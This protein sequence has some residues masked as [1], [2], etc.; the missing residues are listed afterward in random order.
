[1]ASRPLAAPE[2]ESSEEGDLVELVLRDQAEKAVYPERID[3]VVVGRVVEIA[4]S[5]APLVEYDAWPGAPLAARSVLPIGADHV[6]RECALVFEGHQPDKP[7]LIGLMFEPAPVVAP[8]A[9]D[10][11]PAGDAQ[12][13][14]PVSLERE[15]ERVVFEAGK[16]IVLKC[17]KASITLTRAGK[18]LI[19]GAYLLARSSGVNRIQGGSVQ[20]N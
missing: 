10:A 3:G 15:G 12:V 16:E 9:A 19:K 8:D 18:I 14:A 13:A 2:V 5:G 4:P 20:I 6:G 7:I 1:M 17:G 11:E